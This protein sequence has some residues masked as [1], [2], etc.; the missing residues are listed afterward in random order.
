MHK[1]TQPLL[2]A[3]ADGA[4]DHNAGCG[5]GAIAD[6]RQN[7]IYLHR[8]RVGRRGIAAEMTEDTGLYH[9]R[10]APERLIDEHRQGNVHVILHIAGVDVNQLAQA[11]VQLVLLKLQVVDNDEQLHTAGNQRCD[12][13]TAHARLRTAEVAVDQAVVQAHVDDERRTRDHVT[14]L[15]YT[16]RAEGCD[17]NIGYCKDNI[18][19]ADDLEIL[20]TFRDNRWRVGQ[21][22]QQLVRE[23][24]HNAE[25]QHRQ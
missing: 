25:H 1:R 17:Q 22:R 3:L 21:Q 13:R 19:K 11:Q 9:L 8:D 2:V 12:S 14:D 23:E 7:L 4:A 20:F 16:D 10:D 24:Q 18:G 5:R 6:N 15:Y